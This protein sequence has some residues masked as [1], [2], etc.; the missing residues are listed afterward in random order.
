[1][2]LV[3]RVEADAQDTDRRR[4]PTLIDNGATHLTVVRGFDSRRSG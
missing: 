1:M 3:N 2:L 4:Q